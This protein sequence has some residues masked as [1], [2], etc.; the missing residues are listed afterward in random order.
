ML[1]VDCI[2]LDQKGGKVGYN[3]G[4]GDKEKVANEP[5]AA[6]RLN[7]ES[8]GP[9]LP[10]HAL[11]PLVVAVAAEALVEVEVAALGAARA[12]AQLE[13][14]EPIRRQLDDGSDG[15]DGKA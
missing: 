10:A 1:C 12:E 7:T 9:S 6:G 11:G 8:I 15:A 3:H 2:L 14:G 5:L 13:V 4:H